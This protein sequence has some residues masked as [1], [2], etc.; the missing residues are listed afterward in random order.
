MIRLIENKE[1]EKFLSIYMNPYIYKMMKK[2]GDIDNLNK[3]FEQNR[4]QILL[5]HLKKA[6]NLKP[7]IKK[8]TSTARYDCEDFIKPLVLKRIK[9]RWVLHN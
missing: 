6:T 4:A 5:Y 1:H 2:Q 3:D 7:F 9:G 8:E